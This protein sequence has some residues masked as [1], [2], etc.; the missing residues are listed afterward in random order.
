LL[1]WFDEDRLMPQVRKAPTRDSIV[2]GTVRILGVPLVIRN[3]IHTFRDLR[4]EIIKGLPHVVVGHLG[5]FAAGPGKT[6]P[7]KAVIGHVGPVATLNRRKGKRL[8]PNESERA[9]RLAR[10]FATAVHVLGG[11]DDARAFMTSPSRDFSG[12]KPIE[13]AADELGAREVENVL[14]QVYYGM[15]A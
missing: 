8:S 4:V 3:R 2:D 6:Y 12:Q 1:K 11:D 10:V 7:A 13:V 5:A 14:W 9:A 15:S